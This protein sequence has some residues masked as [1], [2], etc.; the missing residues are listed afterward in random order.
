MIAASAVDGVLIGSSSVLVEGNYIGT[1]ASGTHARPNDQ[2]ILTNIGGNNTIG[3][4]VTGAGNLIS[5]NTV[6]G[7]V[8][9]LFETAIS[10]SA[11][12]SGRISAGTSRW[13]TSTE[14]RS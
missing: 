5:G 10:S 14:S 13:A 9:D 12:L 11:I 4:T 6:Q 8:L 7:I 3:G 2:G 1:D